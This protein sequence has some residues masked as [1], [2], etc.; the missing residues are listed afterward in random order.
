VALTL[1]GGRG[2][3]KFARSRQELV[4]LFMTQR[5]SDDLRSVLR[6]RNALGPGLPDFS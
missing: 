6:R 1:C 4:L 3:G 2:R 5:K